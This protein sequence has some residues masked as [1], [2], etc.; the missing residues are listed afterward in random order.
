M[1][2]TEGDPS[3]LSSFPAITRGEVRDG[4]NRQHVCPVQPGEER[5]DTLS[6]IVLHSLGHFDPVSFQPDPP[7]DSAP[8][9]RG[10][11]GR[12]Q[13]QSRSQQNGP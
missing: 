11:C 13:T 7:P 10:E 6:P 1:D 9:W 3:E 12:G 2:G 5:R 4:A 8:D